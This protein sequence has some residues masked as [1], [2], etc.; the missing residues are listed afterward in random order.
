MF[1][2]FTCAK[3]PDTH[4]HWSSTCADA[5]A[6]VLTAYH[7]LSPRHRLAI[8]RV[9][10]SQAEADNSPFR[11][12]FDILLHDVPTFMRYERNNQGYANTSFVL[13]GQSVANADLIEYALTEAKSVTSTRK[14]SV[15]TIS[16]YAAYRRMARLFEDLV[17]TYLLFMSGSW[18]HNNRVWCVYCRHRE[19]V[20]EFAFHKYAAPNAKLIKVQ[21]AQLPADWN[22]DNP[23]KKLD[24]AY[25]PYMLVP[26]VDAFEMLFYQHYRGELD[27]VDMLRS[28]FERD[29]KFVAEGTALLNPGVN[30]G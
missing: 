1:L 28:M 12:D 17:P 23:Y 7:S 20:V 9:G 10:S 19:A 8:V 22:K 6:A 24:I 26:H 5:E 4:E 21:V 3:S 29:A 11:S 14:N 18:P 15:E 25:V 2:L 30:S 13:E 27:D 16:D